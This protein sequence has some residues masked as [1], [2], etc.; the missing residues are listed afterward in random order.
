MIDVNSHCVTTTANAAIAQSLEDCLNALASVAL[1]A[2]R[3]DQDSCKDGTCLNGGSCQ[4]N[5][6]NQFVSVLKVTKES[7]ANKICAAVGM[8][9]D[10]YQLSQNMDTTLAYVGSLYGCLL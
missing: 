1:V 6:K 7:V 9:A 10:V 8:A 2:K 4:R 3:C 5:S